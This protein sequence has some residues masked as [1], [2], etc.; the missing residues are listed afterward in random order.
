MGDDFKEIFDSGVRTGLDI[1]RALALGADFVLLGRPFMYGVAALGE[2]GGA[3]AIEILC[4][5][6]K[7]KMIQ[8]GYRQ[9]VE[10]P[11]RLRVG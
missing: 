9:L 5:D 1:I 11:A 8:L 3:H 10:L 2:A 4:D 7:N 6:L